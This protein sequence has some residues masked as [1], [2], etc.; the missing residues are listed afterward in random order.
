MALLASCRKIDLE[1]M[2]GSPVFT[3]T[4]DLDGDQHLWQAGLE[5]YY[6]FSSFEKDALN[7]Y[8][9]SG[10]FAKDDG[11]FGETLTV[12]IRDFQQVPTGT[13]SIKQALD[14]D[15]SFA[16]NSGIDTIWKTVVDT[17]GWNTIFDASGSILPNI[18]VTYTWD[19]GDSTNS[20]TSMQTIPHQYGMLP[21]QPVK[22][23]IASPNNT[24]VSTMTKALNLDGQNTDC[25]I[26]IEILPYFNP[27]NFDS[28][29]ILNVLPIGAYPFDYAWNNNSVDS[30]Y[31][32][33]DS[34]SII[35]A[36][37]TVTDAN[38]CTVSSSISTLLQGASLP[39]I[40][41][42]RFNNSLLIPDTTSVTFIDSIL[43]GDSLQFSKIKVEYTNGNGNFYSSF[44]G[45]QP[46]NSSVNII[47]VK[48]YDNNEK[49]DKTKKV[50]L[51]FT[52]RIWN[53]E[54]EYIDIT[55]G[56]TTIALAYP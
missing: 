24:C 19:F 26:S 9:F 35:S 28:G 50:T 7:V 12:R 30:F 27:I 34:L 43:Y 42:A 25:D 6:M 1:P 56:K 18:P 32:I 15:L 22:L 48:D 46:S 14:L 45:P 17:T 40:C 55:N 2:D 10:S 5:G 44:L 47:E 21:N 36:A 38:G 23:T 29:Y 8:E 52:C 20:N 3:A 39:Q 51:K 33:S 37:V 13:P 41:M 53:I 54:G 49:G 16:S 11:T 4:V 31:V